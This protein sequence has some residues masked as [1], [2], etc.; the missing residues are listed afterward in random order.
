MF[1]RPRLRAFL[2][3]N[4]LIQTL[5]FSGDSRMRSILR[6]TILFRQ[7]RSDTKKALKNSGARV[8]QM[9]FIKKHI[10]DFTALGVK[11]LK[12]KRIWWK[13]NARSIPILCSKRSRKKIIFS[14]SPPTEKN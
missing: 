10:E 4:S 12:R 8:I 14:D 5:R 11:S 13:E 3:V 2:R 1:W 6:G 9:I 7:P